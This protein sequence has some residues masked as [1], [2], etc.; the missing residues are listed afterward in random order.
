MSLRRTKRPKQS[1]RDIA[2]VMCEGT[3]ALNSANEVAKTPVVKYRDVPCLVRYVRASER[4][5]AQQYRASVRYVV[6]HRQPGVNAQDYFCVEGRGKLNVEGTIGDDRNTE[7]Q[8]F[9]SE[10][11]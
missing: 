4:E 6:E 1:P 7:F 10:R 5:Q 2:D 9:C 3:G 8:S 11:A